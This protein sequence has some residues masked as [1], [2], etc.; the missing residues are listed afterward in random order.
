MQNR[1]QSSLE[2][3]GEAF[4]GVNRSPRWD[5]AQLLL[6]VWFGAM[7]MTHGWGKVFGGMERFSEGVAKM[8]FPLP[9]FF[10]WAA[11]LTEAAGGALLI[12]G[13]A[14]RPTSA[15]AATTMLVAAL[16]RH[17]PDPWAKKELALTYVAI[18]IVIAIVG[19]GRYSLDA[20]VR[21]RRGA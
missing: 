18:A 2:E 16:I 8:G 14:T 7:L 19:A 15:L 17:A 13:L 21:R 3:T 20:L 10:A 11:A 6:R 4:P 9:G 1:I 5:I 12:L